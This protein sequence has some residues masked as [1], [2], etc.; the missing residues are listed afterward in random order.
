MATYVMAY[1]FAFPGMIMFRYKQEGIGLRYVHLR[2]CFSA[3]LKRKLRI[4]RWMQHL[5]SIRVLLNSE[6]YII[7]QVSVSLENAFISSILLE[8]KLHHAIEGSDI[9]GKYDPIDLIKP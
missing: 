4:R 1:C 2:V 9:I 8:S 7:Y 6:I 5:R 3:D